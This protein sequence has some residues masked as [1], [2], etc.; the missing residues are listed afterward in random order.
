MVLKTLGYIILVLFC[1]NLIFIVHNIVR[2]LVPLRVKAPLVTVF[3]GLAMLL[4]IS[5]I[6]QISFFVKKDSARPTLTNLHGDRITVQEVFDVVG[7]LAN[8]SIG[9]LFV[10]TMY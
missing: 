9:C 6:I 8:M 1:A 4:T 3:Y 7:F 10:V 2:F 5:K